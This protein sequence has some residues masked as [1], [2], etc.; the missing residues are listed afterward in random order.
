MKERLDL[1]SEQRAEQAEID[2]ELDKEHAQELADLRRD[3]AKQ[4][5]EELDHDKGETVAALKG[6]GMEEDAVNRILKKHEKELRDLQQAQESERGDQQANFEVS[7]ENQIL[8]VYYSHYYARKC[9]QITTGGANI[10][11]LILKA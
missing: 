2:N 6:E 11:V 7:R 10:P 1:V 8:K 9:K 4:T 3:L 5:I